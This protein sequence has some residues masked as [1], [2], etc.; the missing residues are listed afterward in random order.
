MSEHGLPPQLERLLERM[1]NRFPATRCGLIRVLDDRRYFAMLTLTPN[2]SPVEPGE[3][4]VVAEL[5]GISVSSSAA[6][7]ARCCIGIP[8]RAPLSRLDGRGVGGEGGPWQGGADSPDF[9]SVI[10]ARGPV[11]P[12]ARGVGVGVAVVVVPTIQPG[13]YCDGPIVTA[14][15]IPNRQLSGVTLSAVRESRLTH[16]GAAGS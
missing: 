4:R 3:G 1:V 13:L 8:L 16:E 15:T 11:P 10:L 7:R 2:P 6:R 14:P 9:V 5:R 12:P